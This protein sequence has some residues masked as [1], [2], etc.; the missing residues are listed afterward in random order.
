MF[1]LDLGVGEEW[2][3]ETVE[4]VGVVVAVF[5]VTREREGGRRE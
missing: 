1:F 5:V 3:E 2:S 4:E